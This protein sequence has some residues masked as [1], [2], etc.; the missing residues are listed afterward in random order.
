MDVV[1]YPLTARLFLSD[2]ATTSTITENLEQRIVHNTRN[3]ALP[4]SL[5]GSG[6]IYANVSRKQIYE[7]SIVTIAIA[8]IYLQ[9]L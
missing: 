8:V 5:V 1:R 6:L 3:A 7:E 4:Q 2:P 9:G